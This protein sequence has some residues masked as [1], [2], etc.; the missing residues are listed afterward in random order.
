MGARTGKS[1]AATPTRCR[2]AKQKKYAASDRVTHKA[3]LNEKRG[4]QLELITKH[5]VI[6]S[7]NTF[8]LKYLLSACLILAG[9]TTDLNGQNDLPISTSLT[10]DRAAT[11]NNSGEVLQVAMI[12]N[13]SKETKGSGFI[14]QGGYLITNYHVVANAGLNDLVIVFPDGSYTNPNK[15]RVDTLKD[16]AALKIEGLTAPGI[17][18]GSSEKISVGSQVYTWGYPLGYSSPTPILI[19]GYLSGFNML[20][21]EN[22]RRTVDHLVVNGAFNPGNSGGALMSN[23]E[24]IGVVQSKHAPISKYHQSIIDVLSSNP[25][26]VQYTKTNA[27]GQEERRSEAQLMADMI[28]YFR[29][30]TQVMIGEAVTVEELKEFLAKNNIGY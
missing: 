2:L 10:I 8:M 22:G 7:N 24:V 11:Y 20:L 5:I 23:G 15:V 13:S 21:D 18:L 1:R 27:K 26:G 6:F 16:L 4:N 17:P 12:I 29:E 19:V 9:I 25:S 14:I 3:S 30:L 28:L